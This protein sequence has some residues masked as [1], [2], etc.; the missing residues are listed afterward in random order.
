MA[1][2]V[3][4]MFSV[5]ETPWHGLGT[6]IEEAPTSKDALILSGLDWKVR[7]ENV[8]VNGV[9]A[10]GYR[11]NV[12]DIDNSIL[13][14][15]SSRYKIVQN[16]EAFSFT[17]ELLGEGVKYETA[18]SLAGG[19][20]VWMLAKLEGTKLCGEDFDNYLVF[21]N[22]HDGS[23]S[24]KVA[25]TP[26]R[27]V[28][29]NTLNLALKSAKRT[30]A[31]EHRGNIEDKMEEAKRTLQNAETY[32]A[33]LENEFAELKDKSL[34][35]SD[36]DDLIAQLLP[37]NFDEEDPDNKR[38]VENILDMR[39]RLN[40]RFWQAPDLIDTPVT[41][42]RFVNAVSDFATHEDPKRNTANWK[43]NRFINTIEGNAIIDKAY[44]LV[45]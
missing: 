6:I 28:C 29:Q 20:K 22:S 39:S 36:V 41:A 10:D 38:K 7:S 18:G 27:V 37:M 4:T 34:F 44:K 2:N 45:A 25:I 33:A 8:T 30:W 32:M 11:A 21:T 26:V 43:D 1:A 12:R 14:I 23:G 42:Y 3:E 35:Y 13:G 9:I 15:V 24:I 16:E 31:C 40:Y 5:R 19:K 17:D